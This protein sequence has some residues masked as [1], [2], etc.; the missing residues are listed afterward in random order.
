MA[1]R[2]GAAL[3]ILAG[4]ADRE[5]LL[6][7]CRERQVLGHG[8]VD[9][10]AGL[11]HLAAALEQAADGLVGVEILRQRGDAPA[12]LLQRVDGNARI[13]A[14]RLVLWQPNA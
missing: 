12:D 1:L 4:Q 13:A 10:L 11:D 6:D 14:S 9:T 8:P 5:A 2:E 7:E 3:A